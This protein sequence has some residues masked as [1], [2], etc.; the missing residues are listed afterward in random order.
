MRRKTRADQRAGRSRSA[1]SPPLARSLTA[2]TQ[3]ELRSS[4][5]EVDYK[6]ES[7]L[8]GDLLRACRSVCPEWCAANSHAL[9]GSLP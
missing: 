2:M 4:D 1:A 5:V 3:E 6:N 9:C 8:N 7:T